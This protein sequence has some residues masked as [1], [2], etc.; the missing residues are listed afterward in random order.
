MRKFTLFLMSLFL[1]VG[2]M[3][4]TPIK[5]ADFDAT[6]TYRIYNKA[7]DKGDATWKAMAHN[8]TGGACLK[9][10]N[11][12]DNAQLWQFVDAGEGRYYLYNVDLGKYLNGVAGNSGVSLVAESG[13]MP[14]ALVYDED[15]ERI[16]FYHTNIDEPRSYLWN[17]GNNNLFGWKDNTNKN[18]MFY[19]EE[20]KIATEEET[21]AAREAFN[22]AYAAATEVIIASGYSATEAED[23]PL[24][25]TNE[26]AAYYIWTNAQEP[27]EGPISKLVDGNTENQNFFHTQWSNPVPAGPH[28]IE[29]DLGEDCNLD[30]FIIKY[31]TRI[32]NGGNI[33]DFPDVIE[34]VG[35]NDK[36]GTYTHIATFNENLPQSQGQQWVST[37]IKNDG[38]RFL[39][40]N[41][42]AEKVFW[43]MA[44]FDITIP[45]SVSVN[46]GYESLIDE[47]T[48]LKEAYDNA[49]NNAN[50]GYNDYVEATNAL[51]SALAAIYT[52]YTLN[53]TN[54]GWAT[55]YL[56]FPATIPAFDGDDAGAYIVTGVKDGNWLNLEKV[57][58]V[59]P[60]NTGI[61]VKANEGEYTFAYSTDEAADVAENLLK[62]TVATTSVEGEAYVLGY[63]EDTN[64][65]V[66]GKAKMNG[67]SW[68]NNAYKAYLPVSA[69]PA[70]ANAA[71]YS[72]RFGEGTTGVE[73]VE[74]ENTVKVIYDLTGRRV[75]AITAPG[76]YIVNGVKRVVR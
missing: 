35:S 66:F 52:P 57:E 4:Q 9:S 13:A 61:I 20:V 15:G 63:A 68:V 25:T 38:Y 24:Q 22:A 34:I 69:L 45:S 70:G 67:T 71:Y 18:H 27:N 40:F 6:K 3:A 17:D 7:V 48:V 53:V 43:H 19:L 55:L 76:I 75:E 31:S 8:A 74:V 51:T 42:T 41:V 60:A 23:L 47:I 44:E 58:G 56:D 37:V 5:S 46:E 14:Y 59:L 54:A 39:R 12:A 64:E 50:Y 33:V 65:V 2:A 1:S 28:Y 11:V 62:G 26:N 16:A 10:Y 30:E 29:V 32:N 73:N 49:S 21:A 72:F 36:N